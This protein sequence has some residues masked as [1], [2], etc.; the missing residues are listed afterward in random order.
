[1]ERINSLRYCEQEVAAAWEEHRARGAGAGRRQQ[2]DRASLPGAAEHLEVAAQA[3]QTAGQT[4]G[5]PAAARRAL[6]EVAGEL[7]TLSTRVRAGKLRPEQLDGET[8]KLEHDL[9]IA[10]IE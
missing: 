9:Q 6:L 3:C 8:G 7:E 2:R 10:E 5:L 4:A 1:M